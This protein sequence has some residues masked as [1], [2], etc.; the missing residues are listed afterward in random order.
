MN[1]RYL[2]LLQNSYIPWLCPL[3]PQRIFSGLFEMLSLGL[4]VCLPGL[5]ICWVKH[6]SQ[7]LDCVFFP[8]NTSLGYSS[9]MLNTAVSSSTVNFSCLKCAGLWEHTKKCGT[10]S[11]VMECLCSLMSGKINVI[12]KRLLFYSIWIVIKSH[13]LGQFW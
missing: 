1:F 4:E 2:L 13:F 10:P 3:P 5:N 9:Y 8:V 7:L 6:N 11:I 12:L